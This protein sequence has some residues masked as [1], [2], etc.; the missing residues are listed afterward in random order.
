MRIGEDIPSHG[1]LRLNEVAATQAAKQAGLSP[2][3]T[4]SEPG[5]M[6]LHFIEGRTLVPEDLRD[7]TRL[8]S[9]VRMIHTFHHEVP[10]YL[11]GPVLM[12]WVFHVI[13]D[14]AA[15]LGEGRSAPMPLLNDLLAANFIDDGL[16]RRFSAMKCASLLR[17]TMWS[18]VSKIHSTLDFDYAAYTVKNLALFEPPTT[19]S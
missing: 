6:V 16:V 15:T 10:K 17:E 9:L 12:F 1:V 5:A 8:E 11:R 18:K 4:Y 19:S 13:R 7:L 14:Y 3:V 2:A